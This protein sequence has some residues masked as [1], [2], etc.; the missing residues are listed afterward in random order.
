MF[1]NT[2][3]AFLI[4]DDNYINRFVLKH[5]LKE[6][7]LHMEEAWNGELAVKMLDRLGEDVTIIHLLDLNMPV[8]NGYKVIELMRDNPCKYKNV[9]TIVVSATLYEEFILSGLDAYINAYI[10][11]PLERKELIEIINQLSNRV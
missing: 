7:S 4:T 9:K 6:F 2:K 10:S 1:S 11:K 8:T 5:I 3:L